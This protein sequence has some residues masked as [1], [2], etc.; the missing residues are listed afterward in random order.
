MWS[1]EYNNKFKRQYKNLD[2]KLKKKVDYALNELA[3][4]ENPFELGIL[5]K[6][7]FA[8]VYAY[9]IGKKYRILYGVDIP[10]NLILLIRVGDH[11]MVYNHD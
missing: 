4:S 6:S 7:N 10:H 11:K 1:F 9:E 3:N 2:S 8:T 5:K